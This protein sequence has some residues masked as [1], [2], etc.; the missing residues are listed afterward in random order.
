MRNGEWRMENG[1]FDIRPRHQSTSPTS[2]DINR[3]RCG[4]TLIEVLMAVVILGTVLIGLMQGMSQSL[5]SFSLSKRIHELQDVLYR[6]N[7]EY[8]F[9]FTNDPMEELAVSP[10]S[11]IRDGY[12]YERFCE[13]IEDEET[14][15]LV[16]TRV[17]F[18]SGGGGGNELKV[19]RYV[20]FKQ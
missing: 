1:D 17:W 14:L 4:L 19:V 18:G 11:G 12:S 6:G 9:K 13:E 16:T 10:D 20:Y 15:Y 3:K 2:I 7:L 8:P 5:A